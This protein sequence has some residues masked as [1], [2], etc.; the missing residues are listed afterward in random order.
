MAALPVLTPLAEWRRQK[1]EF[2][3]TDP[4]SPL[5]GVARFR[6]LAYFAEDPA[7]RVVARVTRPAAPRPVRLA[8]SSGEERSFL[9][10]GVARF[11]LGGARHALTLFAPVDA[12]EGPR[13]FLP[14][15]DA[16][17]GAETYGAGRYLDPHLAAP[18]AGNGA[19]VDLV[20]DFNY[21]YHPY[22]A[23]AEG[24]TC[25]FPPAGNRLRVAVRA[26]ERL[27]DPAAP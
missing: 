9:E 26:G 24:Y 5:A 4:R 12:P 27:P 20:L 8:T 2:L 16:T 13:L 15:A 10:Y 18:A 1:D 7:A 25:P 17:S 14:F 3:A 6:G 11:E 21:A 23:F 22:C 19:P